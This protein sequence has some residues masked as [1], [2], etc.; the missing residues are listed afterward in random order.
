M[1]FLEFKLNAQLPTEYQIRIQSASTRLWG[2][3]LNQLVLKDTVKKHDLLNMKSLEIRLD[4]FSILLYQ[5]IPYRFILYGGEIEGTLQVYP[6]PQTI[7]TALDIRPNLNLLLRK[8]NLI[9]S[10]P[11]LNM[12][13]RIN[14]SNPPTGEIQTKVQNLIMSGKTEHTRLMMS[15]PTTE[16][17][18]INVKLSIRQKQTTVSVE[19][20]G[21]IQADLKGTIQNNW[22]NINKSR[23]NLIIKAEFAKKYL[24]QLGIIKDM[25]QSYS[26]PSGKLSVKVNGTY[27]NL[28]VEK[29]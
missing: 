1:S 28:K 19:S 22:T 13:G 15:L 29:I 10:N 25:M 17:S 26:N 23:L 2:L 5:Q 24:T 4:Y 8:T 7:F 14:L 27:N 6:T 11:I 16:L 21:D 20:T 12:K 3:Q 18:S 9:R